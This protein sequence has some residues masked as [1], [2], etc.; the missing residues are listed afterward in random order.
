MSSGS[1]A[2]TFG[3]TC[4]GMM[5]W[6]PIIFRG[7]RDGVDWLSSC[8]PKAT[9]SSSETVL[10]FFGVSGSSRMGSSS[11]AFGA[12]RALTDVTLPTLNCRRRWEL[13]ILPSVA[14]FIGSSLV[15]WIPMPRSSPGVKPNPRN[16]LSASFVRTSLAFVATPRTML[17]LCVSHLPCPRC[18]GGSKGASGDR[19]I[20]F[21]VNCLPLTFSFSS[22][23]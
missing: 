3:S 20:I 18:F 14:V 1:S 5:N 10:D 8:A 19:R 15:I 6:V 21:I 23:L 16:M 11:T 9:C 17:L 7:R 2:S 4:D 13:S 22:R 12:L